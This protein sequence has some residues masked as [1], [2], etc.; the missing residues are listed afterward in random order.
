MDL[1]AFCR[2]CGLVFDSTIGVKN[3]IGLTVENAQDR[4][5]RCNEIAH[6]LEG[7]MNV[8]DDTIELISG[9]T[10]SYET[11][12][13][14]QSLAQQVRDGE[15]SKTEAV[16]KASETDPVAAE[17]FGLWLNIGA[18]FAL[19]M[20][21]FLQLLSAQ[22]DA[23]RALEAEKRRDAQVERLIDA[24]EGVSRNFD[25][26]ASSGSHGEFQANPHSK[27]SQVHPDQN[28]IERADFEAFQRDIVR[29]EIATFRARKKPPEE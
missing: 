26:R 22:S 29:N 23:K 24:I 9:P 16:A 19:L 13:K 21:E 1:P 8:A 17:K 3:V 2:N 20:L 6:I 5:P 11:L 14:I 12:A 28:E 27:R 18:T 10:W 15:I 4:C 25:Q 7:V